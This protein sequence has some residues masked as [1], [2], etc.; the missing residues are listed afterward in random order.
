MWYMWHVG[1]GARGLGG[2][3]LHTPGWTLQCA[4]LYCTRVMIL[5]YAALR[6]TTSLRTGDLAVCPPITGGPTPAH[7]RP[8]ARPSWARLSPPII[9]C[10][11][12]AGPLSPMVPLHGMCSAGLLPVQVLGARGV[13]GALRLPGA[14]DP[15]RRLGGARR[16]QRQARQLSALK[17]VH[18]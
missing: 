15:Q 14:R 18:E 17:T 8:S 9:G 16:G 11:G 5:M 12:W 4:T 13:H 3:A 1:P 2:L 10:P 6:H 7:R